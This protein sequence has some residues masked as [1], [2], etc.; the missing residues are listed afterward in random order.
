MK[1]AKAPIADALASIPLV[2]DIRIDKLDLGERPFRVDSFKSYETVGDE[3]ILE[4]ALFWGGDLELRITAVIQAGPITIDL[5]IDVQNIQFKGLAR[6]TIPLVETLPCAGGVTISL[7]EEPFVDFELNFLGSP[8]LMAFPGVPLAVRTAI[9]VIAGN[10]LVYPNEFMY[11][12]MEGFGRPPPPQGMLKVCVK[13][14]SNLKSSFVD[15]VDPY[16]KLEVR[17]GRPAETSTIK[18]NPNP[19]WDEDIDLVVDN[20]EVQEL[21]IVIL[22]E[23]VLLPDIVG[24]TR[25]ALKASD[26]INNPRQPILVKL[27]VY[28][29]AP[30]GEF[31]V[32]K[33]EDLALAAQNAATDALLYGAAAALPKKR[34]VMG[35]IFRKKAPKVNPDGTITE[36]G[37]GSQTPMYVESSSASSIAATPR[38]MVSPRNN[39]Q[40]SQGSF[41]TKL[42]HPFGGDSRQVERAGTSTGP[43]TILEDGGVVQERQERPPGTVTGSVTLEITYFPF[44]SAA[45]PPA[46]AEIEGAAGAGTAGAQAEM[47]RLASSASGPVPNLRRTLQSQSLG[48]TRDEKGVLT[49]TVNRLKALSEPTDCYVHVRLYDP[50]RLPV[51]DMEARTKVEVNEASPK[52]NFKTDFVNISASSVLTLTVFA[53]Q[54]TMAAL[55][56]LKLPFLQKAKPKSL[57]KVRIPLEDVTREGRVVGIY[58]LQEAQT[59]EMHLNLEWSAVD[60]AGGAREAAAAAVESMGSAKY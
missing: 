33:P 38:S 29:P 55:S 37:T 21:S 4:T 6:L 23:D 53:Q 1:Q 19:V 16:V 11:P 10:M 34:G 12:L 42:L 22:D 54:G 52:F 20:P 30:S 50:H 14:A 41:G 39:P 56:S 32:A 7:L 5:P 47:A 59:G 2:T 35:K 3:I 36:T 46:P 27:A 9:K 44:R 48:R 8:D 51:P 40:K 45:P 18:N 24:G 26:F 17:K 25:I 31:P 13:S 15:T 60:L 58:A 49:V 43:Q 57:G 28:E